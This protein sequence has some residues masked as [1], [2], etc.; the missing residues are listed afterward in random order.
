[1]PLPYITD[2]TDTAWFISLAGALN[3]LG[4]TSQ[5]IRRANVDGKAFHLTGYN[6]P[7][8]FHVSETDIACVVD[9]DPQEVHDEIALYKR[10]EGSVVSVDRGDGVEID[11]VFVQQVTIVDHHRTAL[12]VGGVKDGKW[13][14]FA[15]WV[16]ECTEVPTP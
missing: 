10:L 11:D 12:G 13:K 2:G 15:Q 9:A 6:S 8:S 14:L 4:M 16:L 7:P 5:P 3:P 1:M